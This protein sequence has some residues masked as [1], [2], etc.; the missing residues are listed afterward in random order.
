M[1]RKD[2]L[3]ILPSLLKNDLINYI[4]KNNLNEDSWLFTSYNGH[5]STRSIQEIIKKASK[6]AKINK[7]IHPHTLRHS[8]ATH[9]IEDGYDLT[10]VQ[11]LFGHKSPETTMIYVHMANPKLLSVK[12]PLDNLNLRHNNEKQSY[13]FKNSVDTDFIA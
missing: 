13:E 12:S 10:I 4:N 6:K 2:R 3:F 5:I 8:Y 11:S 1:G 9:L 7:K